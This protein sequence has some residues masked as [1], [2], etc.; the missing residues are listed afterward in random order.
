MIVF[1]S[2]QKSYHGGFNSASKSLK[3]ASE[4]RKIRFV[5]FFCS[6]FYSILFSSIHLSIPLESKTDFNLEIYI[7]WVQDIQDI[8]NMNKMVL[9]SDQLNYLPSYWCSTIWN[10]RKIAKSRYNPNKA[11][12]KESLQVNRGN[13][14]N[15]I[16]PSKY[17]IILGR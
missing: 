5:N 13:I 2:I 17:F 8:D 4:W 9:K 7:T 10:L 16:S 3:K 1:L 12:F 14:C 6:F 15:R 11:T